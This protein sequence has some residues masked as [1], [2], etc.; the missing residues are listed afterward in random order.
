MTE[1]M[2]GL[3]QIARLGHPILRTPAGPADLLA[4]DATQG[5]I[6]DRLSTL[7]DSNGVGIA[8]PPA[9]ESAAR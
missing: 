6:A 7:E 2:A 9:C 3:R 4:P 5:L 1:S 8:A